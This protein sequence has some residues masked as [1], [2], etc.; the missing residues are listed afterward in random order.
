[1]ITINSTVP[2]QMTVCGPAKS[3]TISIY[4]PSPFLLTN[5]TLLL[6]LPP[7]I[8]YQTGSITGATELYTSVPN[9]PVFLLPD[10]PNLTTVNITFIATASCDVMPFLSGGGI[11]ENNIR[12]NYFANGATNYDVHTSPTYIVRQPNVSISAITNQSYTGNI[13]DI[14]TRCIT[15]TNGG[16]GELSQFTLTDVHGSGIQ[17]TAVS[18]GAWTN[19][20]LTET[21]VLTGAHFLTIGDGDNLFE[22]GESIT[23]C[24]TVNV[25]NCI[26]VASA[27]EA[28]WGCN[29]EHCQTSVSSGNV[30][31]PN[32]IPNLV[33]TPIP[34]MNSCLGAGNASLQQLKII[35]TGLGKA[36]NVLLDVFQA[37]N[38][39]YQAN[40]GSN[41][42]SASFTL[43]IGVAGTPAS[44]TPTNTFSTAALGCMSSPI[45][46]VMFTIPAINAGDTVYVK[47]NS[48]SCCYNAC[49]G[50][51]GHYDI[52]GWRF[53]GSYENI[54][55]STY[56]IPEIWGKTY[57]RMRAG[58]TNNGSPSTLSTG[59]TGTFNYLFSFYENSYPVGP[60]AYWKFEFTLPPCLTYGGSLSILRSNGINTWNPASVTTSGNVVTAIFNGNAPWSLTQ[61][62]IK[63]DLTVDCAGCG[64]TGGAGAVSIKSFYIPNG[65]C[66]CQIGVSCQSASISVV[67]P[68]PCPEG[69]L[70]NNFDIKRTSYGLPDNEAGGGNGIPDSGGSLDFTKIKTDRAMFGD[71]I[72][73][74]F[75]G[76]VRTS[77]SYP[78]WQ[79][80]YAISSITNGNRIDS[81]DASLKIYRG[82]ALIINCNTIKP[83]ITNSGSTRVF[84]Y[85]L[86]VPANPCLAG[87]T[88]LNDDSVV[89]KPRYKVRSNIGNAT[90]LNCYATNEFYLSD[91]G[92]FPTP[93]TPVANKFQCDNFNGN[94]SI[95]GY[96]FTNHGPDNYSVTSCNDVTVNQNYYLSV[97]PCC[98]NYAGGNLFPFEYRNWSHI[99]IL[100]AIVP[101]GYNF[102]SARFNQTRTAGTLVT[103]TSAWIPL[104]PLDPNSDT[105]TFPVEQYF[106]GYGG[107]LPLS[108]D[109]YHGTLQVTIKPSCG[110]I[111]TLSQGIRHNWDFAVTPNNYLT[112]PGSAATFF[113]VMQDYIVYEAPVLFLQSTLPSVNAPNTD[114]SW[115]IS[116]SNTS[117]ISNALNTWLSGPA[118][119]GVTITQ[120]FDIDSG[121]IILPVGDIY[122]V[123][124]VNSGAV[125]NFRI[126]AGF[127]S[128]LKDS[129]II[130]SGWN[131]NAGYPATLSAYP[132]TPK[133]ITLALTPL[134]P[135][136]MVNV[137]APPGTILLCDTA[138][139]I[140][141]GVNVQLGTAYHVFL[142]AVLPLGV[143]IIPGSSQLSYPVSNPYI[144][145]SDPAFMGGT[146]WQWDIS[147]TDS[148]I[149]A[150]GLKGILESALNSFRLTF[151]VVTSCGYTSGSII[152][153]NLKGK[154][155]CGMATGQEVALSSQLGITGATTPYFT[156]IKLLTT[157]IS[158]C[159]NNSTMQVSVI[160]NGPLAFADTDSVIVQLPPG[161][162]FVAGSFVGIHNP[163]GI[164]VPTQFTLNGSIFLVW[165]MTAG[166]T[167]GDSCVFSFNYQGDP[168]ALSCQITQFEAHTTSSTDVLC[169]Q[170]GDN[171]GINITTGDTTLSVFTYKA[172]LSLNNG[173]AIAI[174]NPPS[175][176]TVT[177][178]LDI[179]N[180][181]QAILSGANSIL[182][183]YYDINGNG[184]YNTG[185]VFLVQDT[186]LVTNNAVIPYTK[187][188]N[189]PAGNAC[190]IIAIINTAVNPCVCNASQLLILPILISSGNDSSLCSGETMVLSTLPVTGYTYSWSPP[191]DLSDANIANPVLTALNISTAPVS[192]DYIITTNRMGCISKD[193][194]QI[195]VNPVPVSNAGAD[196][197]TCSIS[198]LGELGTPATSG[199]TYSWIP[200]TGLSDTTVSDPDVALATPGSITYTVT[201]TVFGC[202]SS[203]S[204][205]VQVNPLPTATIAGTASVCV[206]AADPLITFTGANATPPYTFTYTVNNGGNQTISTTAGNSITIP[207]TTTMADTFIYTLISVQDASST[208]CSQLQTGSATITVNPLPTA[209]IA[210]TISVC[211]NDTSPNITFTG[212]DGTIP[213]TF[214]YKING[215]ATQTV[216]S[217]GNSVTVPAPATATGTFIYSLTGVEDATS[218]YQLQSGTATITVNPLPTATVFGTTSV[219]KGGTVPNIVFSASGSTPPYS[220]TYT[221]NGVIQPVLVI[222]GGNSISVPAATSAA[223]IFVYALVNI[224]DASSTS[225]LQT[226]NGSATV[227]VNPL[228][229]ASIAGTIQV[230]IG[231]PFPV[232]TLT[233]AGGQAPYTFTYTI[234]GVMM[235][236]I[237]STGD[238]AT[239]SVSTAFSNTFVYS[240]V[241]VADASLPSCS[242]PQSGSATVA[243]NPLPTATISGTTTVCKNAPPPNVTLT[244]VIGTAPFLFTYS[245]NGGA[246]QSVSSLN[247][248]SVTF[249][250]ATDTEGLITYTLLSVQDS[251]TSICFQTQNNIVTVTIKPLPTG[252][253]GGTAAV[254]AGSP[255][256]DITFTGASGTAPYTFTY[257]I[258]GLV[259]PTVTTSVGNSISV[260]AQTT[261]PGTFTYTLESIKDA[262]IISCNNLVG[263]TALI[264]IN[265][266]PVVNFKVNDSAGCE[267]LC[268]TFTDLS[269]IA[270]G[271]SN[272][273]WLWGFGDG[274]TSPESFH[275]YTN[276]SVFQP[277]SLNVTLTVTSDSGCTGTLSKNN[278]VT[279]YPN[280]EAGFTVQP[281]VAT[282]INPVVLVL[283]ASTGANFWEWDYGDFQ[284]DSLFN[285][286]AHT[287]P[288]TG[289]YTITLITS[290]NY[291][292]VDTAYQSII[293][294]PDFA[295]YVPNAFSPNDDGI[296]DTFSGKG[297]FITQYDMTIFDRW[298]NLIYKTDSINKPWD[299]KANN[300]SKMAQAD[301]YIYLIKV[302]DIRLENHKY[303]G[304]VTLVR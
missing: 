66:S 223:G 46:R 35:N 292:C 125:R 178:N 24:E 100:T 186:L 109:G 120:L 287:Y 139:Y 140:A 48:Y 291:G 286:P 111:P 177:V 254:C 23:I 27:F 144:S 69:M 59:Q 180:T 195:T 73:S 221:I 131:C 145:I 303:T 117:N 249:P 189:V 6:S 70:F 14:Y 163:P 276:S 264:T 233:G 82:G 86:S 88:Y 19:S 45:G 217:I 83:V 176:E 258:N 274:G 12:V 47:W 18:A 288:D 192:T 207:V 160:N 263:S 194:I 201:T 130:Y 200:A 253:I 30:V 137:T 41:I 284:I 136:L 90:P 129:I 135:A 40:L 187:T 2:T 153:F 171:C 159:A 167:V 77:L 285:P 142:V 1:M 300:G 39:G 252:S 44:I 172:Y 266:N 97:G 197:T 13:G 281:A 206:N 215:G 85:N 55:Q 67:C 224:Q 235:P 242:Q 115:D 256:P 10:I 193:T 155:A 181:G 275:C 36:V 75:N 269:S 299:G 212:A 199:Y 58:L 257:S 60:G 126:T 272:A 54:C 170:T 301:V 302:T 128:C 205:T 231:D 65:S 246:V 17:I 25:L 61:A 62:E 29:T 105:L 173:S 250:V 50:G 43:Q 296:N 190:S 119:S 78:S 184:I 138:S 49:T 229:T 227:T 151:K 265:P 123:G 81:L 56:V 289:T 89:F 132:C 149:N 7:G 169:T 150:D 166:I 158:P 295:F 84:K 102:I 51:S 244:G 38:I 146:T 93:P 5:D 28:F 238:S 53:A 94:L 124:T 104:T 26:S 91:I 21:I 15:I 294:E 161:V 278:F 162:S 122:Q 96:Y 33:I 31:F 228:P 210:G 103:N 211:K 106:D 214:T 245:I 127:T 168:V 219:C 198:S 174:P 74:H 148:I 20:G 268:V 72:T 87:Y 32:L 225:C 262:G 237:T 203:D 110:V 42:D 114:A 290:T 261:S 240:L 298:G 64:G 216:T 101:A 279:V 232:I 183:F 80:C 118:I 95:I 107:T 204:V 208:A 16:L 267:P 218:C 234:N 133:S 191:T 280:P 243:V 99:N 57:S 196:T 220:V 79:Y 277:L 152:A 202:T 154:A 143:T 304:I 121:I 226:L 11:I 283:D 222:P 247:A 293:I 98:N 63:I 4:N 116:I 248:N 182:Q 230:C 3:F 134:M 22:N 9:Q 68:G 251:S 92:I 236:V 165:K 179:T 271:I 273:Q 270:S 113:P 188:F 37:T 213:Y 112:G 164:S 260:A 209:T 8:A 255:A 141:E 147:S 297:V 52:N 175:G 239:V 108:D 34:S 282:I 157:Y 156:E 259:Q 76:T 241:S 71:T 185:D